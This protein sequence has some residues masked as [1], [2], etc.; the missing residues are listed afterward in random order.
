MITFLL[1]LTSLAPWTGTLVPDSEGLKKVTHF[2]SNRDAGRGIV[3]MQIE[4][5][6]TEGQAGASAN[7][8]W[9]RIQLNY[10][11]SR[12]I[13]WEVRS[14]N[15]ECAVLDFG[16]IET[17]VLPTEFSFSSEYPGVTVAP[18]VV[19]A[20]YTGAYIAAASSRAMPDGCQN[21]VSNASDA[22]K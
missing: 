7:A 17:A 21:T 5:C 19:P 1:L 20:N 22:K 8:P 2:Q 18:L 15:P 13:A 16:L 12:L 9:G 10:A 11:A 4:F 14:G 3:V 6:L